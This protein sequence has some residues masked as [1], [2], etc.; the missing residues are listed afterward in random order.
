MFSSP[1]LWVTIFGVIGGMA[2]IMYSVH[3]INK[4]FANETKDLLVTEQGNHRIELVN[5]D[6]IVKDNS[7]TLNIKNTKG[8][9]GR[10]TQIMP[11]ILLGIFFILAL[12][13]NY[14]R[15]QLLKNSK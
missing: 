1:N 4:L 15:K 10:M 12:F 6:K 5:F 14:Y 9:N 8:V 13:R 7:I 3:Y 2:F 11:F